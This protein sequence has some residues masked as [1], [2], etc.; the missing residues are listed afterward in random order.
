MPLVNLHAFP[1]LCTKRELKDQLIFSNRIACCP[2]V[3][4]LSEI[5]FKNPSSFPELVVQF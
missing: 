4:R 1:L 5:F 2:S 3:R